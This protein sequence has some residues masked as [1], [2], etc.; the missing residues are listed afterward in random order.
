VERR[1][2]KS[3]LGLRN[4]LSVIDRYGE[5]VVGVVLLGT[6][7][8]LPACDRYFIYGF[9]TGGS[10]YSRVNSNF[11]ERILSFCNRNLGELQAE[12]PMIERAG[13]MRYHLMRIVD[14][15]FWQIDFDV[16]NAMRY[17]R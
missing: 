15:H 1:Y 10:K 6:F 14:M 16:D 8:C 5:I 9:K 4:H 7:G 2:G 13:G 17:K 11:V 12:Q 3:G